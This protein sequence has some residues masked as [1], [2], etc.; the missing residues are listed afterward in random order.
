[1]KKINCLF[2]GVYVYTKIIGESADTKKATLLREESFQD[3]KRGFF[4][5]PITLEN[6]GRGIFKFSGIIEDGSGISSVEGEILGP[7]M[8][9]KKQYISGMFESQIVEYEVTQMNED[10]VSTF[11]GTW[12]NSG[13]I[14]RAT[15]SI[16][17]E[18]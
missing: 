4:S 11:I 17:F 6:H 16:V 10:N 3:L 2:I 9:F 15:C 1:M 8:K 5:G 7:F 12:K 18:Q 13:K 14:G